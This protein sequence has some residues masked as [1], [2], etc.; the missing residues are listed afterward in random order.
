M[1]KSIETLSSVAFG[2]FSHAL[3]LACFEEALAFLLLLPPA[4]LAIVNFNSYLRAKHRPLRRHTYHTGYH[5]SKV[6]ERLG[7]RLS[8]SYW[9]TAYNGYSEY[10]YP[11]IF[12]AYPTQARLAGRAGRTHRSHH[13]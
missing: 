10:K 5:H 11:F 9:K 1:S 12:N 4:R 3:L 13:R 7:L 6:A 8:S 2:A